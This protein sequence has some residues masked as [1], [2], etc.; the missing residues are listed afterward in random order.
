M[1][2]GGQANKVIQLGR[3]LGDESL[4]V[5]DPNAHTVLL[6]WAVQDWDPEVRKA[7]IT[8]PG[9]FRRQNSAK[10]LISLLLLANNG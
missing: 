7:S 1:T 6:Y 9:K 3:G 8:L 10:F 5:S 2:R 4:E